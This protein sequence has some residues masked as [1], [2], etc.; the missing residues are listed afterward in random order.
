LQCLCG[1]AESLHEEFG[2][3]L[4]FRSYV[5]PPPPPQRRSGDADKK[6]GR[7]GRARESERERERERERKVPGG[8]GLEEAGGVGQG[9]ELVL[10][11]RK[12]I[13]WAVSVVECQRL[14]LVVT[15]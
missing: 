12:R 11:V 1:I 3:P 6:V 5:P 8:G 9:R 2:R 10:G 15:S 14:P 7:A 4:Q 13:A